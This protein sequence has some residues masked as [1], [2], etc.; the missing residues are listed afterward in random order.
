MSRKEKLGSKT[1]AERPTLTREGLRQE[2]DVSQRS[3][4]R[5]EGRL[6]YDNQEQKEGTDIDETVSLTPEEEAV[7]DKRYGQAWPQTGHGKPIQKKQAG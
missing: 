3:R 5:G 6:G 4:R 7:Y 1:D 2:R